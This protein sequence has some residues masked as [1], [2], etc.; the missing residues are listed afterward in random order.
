MSRPGFTKLAKSK[1]INFQNWRPFSGFLIKFS[2][3]F[4]HILYIITKIRPHFV[5]S[6]NALDYLVVV[7][8]V[9][10][11]KFL[12]LGWYVITKGTPFF[13]LLCLLVYP[14]NL[15]LHISFPTIPL[16]W[17]LLQNQNLSSVACSLTRYLLKWGTS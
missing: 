2:I 10:R 4:T 14:E 15:I 7:P 16:V 17:P 11:F 9:P 5:L 6:H 1:S 3:R 13:F 8:Y 12:K